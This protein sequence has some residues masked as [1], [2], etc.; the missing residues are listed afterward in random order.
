MPVVSNIFLCNLVVKIKTLWGYKMLTTGAIEMAVITKEHAKSVTENFARRLNER[1]SELGMSQAD[2]VRATGASKSTV[3][4][5]F[6]GHRVP[7]GN[8]LTFLGRVLRVS[9]DY[10]V[11]NSSA[12]LP[13]RDSDL[14]S[15]P[16][17]NSD[18]PFTGYH[19]AL[20]PELVSGNGDI[21][22]DSTFVFPVS[23]INSLAD[24]RSAA[25]VKASN[26][27]VTLKHGSVVLIDTSV[28][29]LRQSGKYYVMAAGAGFFLIFAT[30][31]AVKGWQIDDGSVKTH[32][33][34]TDIESVKICGV[35]VA[36]LGYL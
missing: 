1:A 36:S 4:D 32:Y 34:V 3:H 15:Y 23:Y 9:Q 19:S 25:F 27:V 14:V 10:L 11:G 31:D 35:G 30:Y 6:K 22:N 18:D 26:N 5:W 17:A 12:K 2:I 28:N 21:N 8:Y 13:G 20:V 16:R 24:R 33:S 29:T 7:T